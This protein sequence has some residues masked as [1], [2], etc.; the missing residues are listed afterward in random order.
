MGFSNTRNV[1]CILQ[2]IKVLILAF[3]VLFVNYSFHIAD[4]Q[5]VEVHFIWKKQSK[6]YGIE[7]HT[8]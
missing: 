1:K 6:E 8:T 2:I 4:A 7:F 3:I 5:T